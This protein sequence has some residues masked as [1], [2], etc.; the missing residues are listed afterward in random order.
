MRPRITGIGS[1][2]APTVSLW[3]RFERNAAFSVRVGG[4]LVSR[5]V[6]RRGFGGARALTLPVIGI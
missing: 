1:P 2:E 4:V 5:H 3:H 6:T